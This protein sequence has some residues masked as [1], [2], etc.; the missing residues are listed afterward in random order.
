MVIDG[1]ASLLGVANGNTHLGVL[2]LDTRKLCERLSL[3]L[4][5]HRPEH[6]V[7]VSVLH[8][9]SPLCSHLL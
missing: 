1:F 6:A 5:I 3:L 2:S 9:V 4:G 8:P 7:T